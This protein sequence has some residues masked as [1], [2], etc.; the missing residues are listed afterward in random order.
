[1]KR[2]DPHRPFV[3]LGLERRR[4]APRTVE[5]RCAPCGTPIAEVF[6]DPDKGTLLSVRQ[7]DAWSID[8]QRRLRADPNTDE[9]GDV[10]DDTAVYWPKDMQLNAAPATVYAD[11]P[12]HPHIVMSVEQIRQS[13]Y[14][15][16]NRSRTVVRRITTL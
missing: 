3:A 5:V 11:C 15:A 4:N 6:I 1:M 8:E 13:H 12:R 2:H 10:I 7:R 9:R 16:L 14:E